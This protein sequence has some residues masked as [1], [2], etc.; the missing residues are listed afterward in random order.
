MR[1]QAEGTARGKSDLIQASSSLREPMGAEEIITSVR[2]RKS[3]LHAEWIEAQRTAGF[4]FGLLTD[5]R[6]DMFLRNVGL[7]ELHG[8]TTRNSSQSPP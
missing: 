6:G 7:S 8:V 3:R 2:I 5:L 4:F 1:R